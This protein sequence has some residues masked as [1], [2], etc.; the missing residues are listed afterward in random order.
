MQNEFVLKKIEDKYSNLL[1]NFLN[2]N[3]CDNEHSKKIFHKD[4]IKEILSSKQNYVF[5][6]LYYNK[7]VAFNHVYIIDNTAIINL[8]VTALNLA[9]LSKVINNKTIEFLK[10]THLYKS[11]SVINR[12]DN[13]IIEYSIPIS[14]IRLS[15]AGIE[16]PVFDKIEIKNN[17]LII[18][19]K[20]HINNIRKLFNNSIYDDN[21][22]P[23]KN[24]FV[25][26]VNVINNIVVDYISV[27]LFHYKFERNITKMAQ[28]S[29]F[30]NNSMDLTNLIALLIDKLNNYGIDQLIYRDYD[31]LDINITKYE[32]INCYTIDT[33]DYT[34]FGIIF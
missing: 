27:Y 20:K 11:I 7:I 4:F 25:S 34:N 2:D 24:I 10:H 3:Y 26:F 6:L 9:E 30:S 18:A 12:T 32:T 1:Y 29:L 14:P 13:G 15:E 8:T 5:V 16:I 19:K 21:F 23:R 31:S 33:N 28:L 17:P 22:L